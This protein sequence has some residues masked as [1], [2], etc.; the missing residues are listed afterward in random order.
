MQPVVA[1]LAAD[2]IEAVAHYYES[3]PETSQP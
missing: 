2:D 1:G 3:V